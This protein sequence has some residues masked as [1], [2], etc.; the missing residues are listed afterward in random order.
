V[1]DP[2][3]R[4]LSGVDVESVPWWECLD[5]GL[6]SHVADDVVVGGWS[7]GGLFALEAATRTRVAGLALVSSTARFPSDADYKGVDVRL[8]RAMQ[9]R[10]ARQPERV[11]ADFA[12]LCIA[13]AR[14][15]AFVESFVEAAASCGVERLA[16][17]LRCLAEMDLRER[18]AD[19]SA[20]TLV[21]HGARDQVI[22]LASGEALAAGLERARLAVL[23]AAPHALLHTHAAAVARELESLLD[24][25]DA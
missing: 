8:L 24:G 3:V 21:I 13:P 14:D 23:P 9:M 6:A 1:W 12:A 20:R 7:L 10:L 5:R 22:P 17:G 4:R 15:D 16:A 2:V 19:V 18:L 11:L 25:Q